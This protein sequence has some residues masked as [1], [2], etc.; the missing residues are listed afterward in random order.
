MSKRTMTIMHYKRP[1]IKSVEMTIIST[2]FETSTYDID[3]GFMV[4]VVYMPDQE[5]YKVWL[6]HKDYGPKVLIRTIFGHDVPNSLMLMQELKDS[7]EDHVHSYARYF[8]A[9]ITN[10]TCV[11]SLW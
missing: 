3:E 5:M 1:S 10:K 7:L 2:N 8:S 11:K 4:D 9:R 6:Y